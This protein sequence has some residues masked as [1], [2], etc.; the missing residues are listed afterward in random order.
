M[1]R[2][3]CCA[4]RD[5]IQ[6]PVRCHWLNSRANPTS[7]SKPP[8]EKHPVPIQSNPPVFRP[9]LL[10]SPLPH[11]PH[12]PAAV[13][14]LLLHPSIPSSPKSLASNRSIVCPSFAHQGRALASGTAPE[15]LA[16]CSLCSTASVLL[17][18]TFYDHLQVDPGPTA[19]HQIDSSERQIEYRNAWSLIRSHLVDSSF[20]AASLC[21]AWTTSNLD[22]AM[23]VPSV[24][25]STWLT[26]FL[27][28][29][30]PARV[31]ASNILQTDGFSTCMDGGSI[32]VN[33]VNVQY[34]RVSNQVTYDV[35]GSSTKSQNVT[36]T[37]SI[38]VYGDE[39][40]QKDF[41]PCDSGSY[42]EQIC[43]GKSSFLDVKMAV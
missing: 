19:N 8:F 15:Q 29:S 1:A 40:Y 42:I 7:P 39:V 14:S 28:A 32:T 26:T 6:A 43:P 23:K 36:A 30:L 35:S 31:L 27:L 21:L 17:T 34:N 24:A 37:L 20:L 3:R 2:K 5:P 11:Q 16:A 33:S 9:S 41:N 4:A 18:I 13:H 22:T 10:S 12:F 25:K 38:T